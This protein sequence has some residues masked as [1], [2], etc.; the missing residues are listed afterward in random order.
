MLSITALIMLFLIRW[1]SVYDFTNARC[2]FHIV[3]FPTLYI[4]LQFQEE[5]GFVSRLCKLICFSLVFFSVFFFGYFAGWKQWSSCSSSKLS[6]G[7]RSAM[8]V[9]VVVSITRRW[10]FTDHA[11]GWRHR[12]QE[13]HRL[14]V[15]MRRLQWV[16]STRTRPTRLVAV[17][18]QFLWQCQS[19]VSHRGDRLKGLCLTRGTCAYIWQWNTVRMCPKGNEK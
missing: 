14:Q 19:M 16:W 15:H 11:C 18:R 10:S 12:R 2:I 8:C 5:T 6:S 4:P 17:E 13:L 3:A 7:S 1:R 9:S